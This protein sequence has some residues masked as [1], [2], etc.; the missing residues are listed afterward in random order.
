MPTARSAQQTL[1]SIDSIWL[2][3]FKSIKDWSKNKGK[4]LGRPNLPK[5]KS[6]N[7]RGVLTLTNQD[8]KLRENIIKFPK[9]FNGFEIKTICIEREGFVSLQ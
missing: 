8:V 4:S 1:R 3:F 9:S 7:S 2:S 6:K 5:Y